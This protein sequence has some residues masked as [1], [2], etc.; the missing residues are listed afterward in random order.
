MNFEPTGEG[1]RYRVPQMGDD[2]DAQSGLGRLGPGTAAGR[3]G[4]SL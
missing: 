1:F 2:A 3:A 4:H